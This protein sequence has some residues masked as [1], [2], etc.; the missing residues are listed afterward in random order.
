MKMS[1]D[2]IPDKGR[3]RPKYALSYTIPDFETKLLLQW[4]KD[5]KEDLDYVN[6]KF[7]LFHSCLQGMAVTKWDLC[8]T[9]YKG[10]KQTKK[11]FKQCLRDYLKTATKGT[12]LGDHI[13]QWLRIRSKPGPMQFEDFL[14]C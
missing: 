7:D 10:T 12:N 5:H 6:K 3:F 9:K 14:N 13:I 2:V 1:C 8:S 11:N 4:D